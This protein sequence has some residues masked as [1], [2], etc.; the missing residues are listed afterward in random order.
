DDYELVQ[1]ARFLTEHIAKL[2]RAAAIHLILATQKV[3]KETVDTRIQE[4]V[5]GRMCFK[6]NTTEGS[7][8][9]LG[10]GK[11]ADLPS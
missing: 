8:R 4:N 11:A 6:L 5:S 1:E 10:H 2:S 7:V 9:M 3:T